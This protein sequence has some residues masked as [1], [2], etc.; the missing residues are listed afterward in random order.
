MKMLR[1][2]TVGNPKKLA[3]P[4]FYAVVANLLSMLPFAFSVEAARILFSY[5][6]FPGET[7]DLER[8]WWVCGGL[9]C[10]IIVIILGEIPAYR[11]AFRSAYKTAADGRV[12]LAEHLRKLPLGYLTRRDPGDLANMM[13]GDFAMLEH[14]ISHLVPQLAGALALPVL[15][16][17]GLAVLDWRMAIAMFAALP[18]AMLMIRATAGLRRRMG[19]RLTRAKLEAGNR[20]Q[21][22]LNGIRVMKAHNLTGDRFVRLERS[23]KRLMLE[24]IKIEGLIGPIV[25]TAVACMRAGLTLVVLVGV[26]LLLGG[27]LDLITLVVFLFVGSRIY[28]PLTTTLIHYTEFRYT[29]QAGER[30]VRL[31]EEP[32]MTGNQTAPEPHP[33]E[34][35]DVVFGYGDKT[36]LHNVSLSIPAGSL[37]ALVGPSGSGKSTVLRL[38]A[39]FYDPQEGVI[40]M[41]GRDVR[42]IDPEALLQNVSMVFQ[43]VY[44][45]QDTI[46]NNIRFGKMDASQQEIEDAA[47]RAC[48]HDFISKLPQG[49][50]TLVGEGGSTLSGG[51]K[52][53]ISIARAILKNAPIVLLDEA[54]ASLDPENERGIQTAINELTRGRTVIVIAHRLK[55]L[56]DAD[57]ILVLDKGRVVEQGSHPELLARGGLYARLWEL[58]QRSGRWSVSS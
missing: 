42:D 13:M 9:A 7:L 38:I 41:G 48:C 27:E 51:E 11:S 21:E 36:I 10:S 37:T 39:R 24:S 40:R 34:L 54:T 43:D 28:E 15:A 19:G 14:S 17:A 32:V 46:G 49:Y 6:A 29:E 22:Y 16:A 25:L 33:I 4:I 56:R 5:Y 30:I 3:W 23:F 47:R 1:N 18:V 31:L 55:T 26:N 2:I 20:M 57:N 53:R 35:Q 58:Q 52:Q 45:F 8:L 50:E 12:D 44:L